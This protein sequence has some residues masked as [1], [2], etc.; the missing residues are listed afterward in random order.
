MK[1]EYIFVH[2]P[3]T[4][5]TSVR[6]L[7]IEIFSEELIS[8]S[9]PVTVLDSDKAKEL[10]KYKIICGHISMTDV[11]RYFPNRKLITFLRNPIDRCLSIYGFF[12]QQSDIPLIHLD[13]IR[14]ENISSE[15]ISI[16]KQ[17]NVNDFF[18]STHPHILQ[19]INNRMTRQ[20]GY[21]AR[22]EDC[23]HLS[24][25]VVLA[26]AKS[27]LSKYFHVGLYENL[28]NDIEE[29]CVKLG[30]DKST[31]LPE[32]NKTSNPIRS[33]EISDELRDRIS[34]LNRLDV[35]L[36]RSIQCDRLTVK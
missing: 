14:N 31:K 7:F 20:I 8:P 1:D 10:N 25:D 11:E 6:N 17:L 33:N 27:N 32:L 36:Y 24:D 26:R 35:E 9:F 5:G 19:N 15:A 21:S 4:A 34:K 16:A 28:E 23:G 29:M 3:K 13:Q 30:I 18:N 12:R 22:F 2:I